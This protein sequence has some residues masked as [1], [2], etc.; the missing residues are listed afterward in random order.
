MPKYRML[1]CEF[2]G[3]RQADP[4]STG[5]AGDLRLRWDRDPDIGQGNHAR[6]YKADTPI[7]MSRNIAMQVAVENNF[8]F[9]VFLDADMAPDLPYP[10][11]KPF[12]ESSWEFIKNHN[13]PCIIA[14]PYSGPPPSE[15]TYVFEYTNTETDD[16]NPNFQ[17]AMVPRS[18]AARMTGIT[19]VAALPTG[20]MIIDMRIIKKM[21]N[22]IFYYEWK[23]DGPICEHCGVKKP[24]P[25]VEKAS[26]E[27]V[28]FSRDVDSM[29]F[30]LYCNWDAWAGHRK[31]KLVGKPGLLGDDV[32]SQQLRGRAA[33][34]EAERKQRELSPSLLSERLA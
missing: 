20:L 1:L 10:G 11:A 29:G 5:Y 27:D 22:P 9:A 18:K 33:E 6:W 25:Q 34:L 31:P 17:L 16:P 4:D 12:W 7:T 24:G 23:D 19:Q 28:S 13:G 26:T 21:R 32:I 30:P 8:D 3:F 14:A 15:L 2:P